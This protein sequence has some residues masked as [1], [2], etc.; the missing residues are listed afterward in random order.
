MEGSSEL[1]VQVAFK[2]SVNLVQ[3]LEICQAAT[4]AEVFAMKSEG[5]RRACVQR[6]RLEFE[7][8]LFEDWKVQPDHTTAPDVEY[9]DPGSGVLTDWN[10]DHYT[11][12][13]P[14][15]YCVFSITSPMLPATEATCDLIGRCA[16]AIRVLAGITEAILFD[17][18]TPYEVTVG[19]GSDGVGLRELQKLYTLLLCGGDHI[20][21]DVHPEYQ[22]F[23]EHMMPCTYSFMRIPTTNNVQIARQEAHM[24]VGYLELMPEAWP[25]AEACDAGHDIKRFI[26]G[27]AESPHIVDRNGE[28]KTEDGELPSVTIRLQYI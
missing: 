21:N 12:W 13:D 3:F 22:R 18:N 6:I 23:R 26:G 5:M 16:D 4:T 20:L 7:D 27:E 24:H 17:K 14:D 19:R 25:W 1:T 11:D 2:F 15:Y 10:P 8:P 28:E 9:R